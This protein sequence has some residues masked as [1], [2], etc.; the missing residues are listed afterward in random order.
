MTQDQVMDRMDQKWIKQL[1][2]HPDDAETLI[3]G[4]LSMILTTEAHKFG[5]LLPEFA[6]SWMKKY[7]NADKAEPNT[8]EQFLQAITEVRNFI[9]DVVYSVH[10][11]YKELEVSEKA[12]K[13][14][15]TSIEDH[16]FEDIYKEVFGLFKRKHAAEDERL[17]KLFEAST[18]F[19]LSQLGVPS[20]LC[21]SDE[22]TDQ[23]SPNLYMKAINCLK[24]ISKC[25]TPSS[26]LRCLIDTAKAIVTCIDD[27]RKAKGLGDGKEQ[28]IV[29]GDEL[30]PLFTYLMI[31]AQ[32]PFVYSESKFID[33]FAADSDLMQEGGYLLATFQMSLTIV[34]KLQQPALEESSVQL[35]LKDST[36]SLSDPSLSD[37]SQSTEVPSSC[38]TSSDSSPADSPAL[39]RND[40]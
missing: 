18:E 11:Y 14:C 21:L 35:S 28:V 40:Q 15:R 30:L 12:T 7:G 37:P 6:Y 23:A 27:Y 8:E 32:I 26:K 36:S 5:K 25:I 3:V 39:V 29:G 24:R 1:R 16:L 10:M 31:K 34:E 22:S 13:L 20:E 2:E 4:H 9:E 19:Q 17:T 38:S 33:F